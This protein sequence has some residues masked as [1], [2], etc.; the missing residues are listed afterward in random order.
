MILLREDQL[1]LV[2][3]I[4]F[5]VI[6]QDSH[7][8]LN[9]TFAILGYDKTELDLVLIQTYPIYKFIINHYLYYFFF[10]QLFSFFI[11]YVW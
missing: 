6:K 1:T 5:F 4:P 11:D 3:L 2:S 10:S 7:G 9:N 8:I